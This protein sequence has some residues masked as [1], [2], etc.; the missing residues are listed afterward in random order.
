MPD[1]LGGMVT[2]PFSTD[3]VASLSA[4]QRSGAFHP[5]TC[6]RDH[7]HGPSPVLEATPAGW[8]CSALATDDAWCS[9]LQDWAHGF[10]ANWSWRRHVDAAQAQ[11]GVTADP[12]EQYGQMVRSVWTEWALEQ[13]SPKESWLLPW[14]ML[15]DG[16]REVDKRIGAAVAA[17]EQR[18]IA[19]LLHKGYGAL[20][21]DTRAVLAAMF[22]RLAAAVTDDQEILA[23]I[24]R[25]LDGES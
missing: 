11:V 25:L 4:Y 6:P 5:F 23:E 18:R 20:D 16:Q 10:M 3:Q 7:V 19:G 21:N 24:A 15:D 8:R 12:R 2:A 22:V 17:A 1:P 13:A 9:Y 14:C